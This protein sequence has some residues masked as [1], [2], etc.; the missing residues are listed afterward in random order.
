MQHQFNYC[1]KIKT[2]NLQ[3]LHLILLYCLYC[4]SE[5]MFFPSNNYPEVSISVRTSEGKLPINSHNKD[6]Q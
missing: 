2:C 5:C 3:C 4:Y 1:K 6:G